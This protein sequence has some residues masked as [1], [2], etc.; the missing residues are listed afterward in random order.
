MKITVLV[1]NTSA[2]GLPTEHGLS[3]WIETSGHKILFDL[4]QG[5]LFAENAAAL[6]ININEA[7][8]AVISH[9]HYDHG[10]GI[11]KF[12]S[13]NSFA[14]VYLH[15]KAFAAY[16]SDKE[17]SPRYIGLD[18][19]QSERIIYTDGISLISKGLTLFSGADGHE[20]FSPANHHILKKEAGELL[21]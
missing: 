10:G 5:S 11:A 8:L 7:E 9:G 4:G 20:Y 1:E 2:H 15:R 13:I 19:E 3:L 16:Y 6:G 18:A 12:L 14:L 21:R 17:G